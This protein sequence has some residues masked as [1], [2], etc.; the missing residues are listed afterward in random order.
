MPDTVLVSLPLSREAAAALGSAEQQERVGRLLSDLVRPSSPETD[1][2][3]TI[4]AELKATVRADGLSD[5]E[6]DA[7]LAAYN[8]ERRL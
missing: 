6:I 4:I 8:A 7:E 5:E 3:A 1:P 2:L